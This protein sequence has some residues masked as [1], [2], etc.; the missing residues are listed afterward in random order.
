MRSEREMIT[1]EH[2]V[3]CTCSSI[4]WMADLLYSAQPASYPNLGTWTLWRRNWPLSALLL[5]TYF[6]SGIHHSAIIW[7]SCRKLPADVG[8]HPL[9]DLRQKHIRRCALR[10][11]DPDVV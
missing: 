6:F 5:Y 11:G 9:R 4:I 3:S 10:E 2:R 8:G 7:T 1:S